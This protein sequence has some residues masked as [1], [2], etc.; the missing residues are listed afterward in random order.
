MESGIPWEL[1][2]PAGTLVFNDYGSVRYYRLEV[3]N[4]MTAAPLRT[5]QFVI[6]QEDGARIGPAY[7]SALVMSF[8]GVLKFDTIAQ[9][10]LMGD[11]LAAWLAT[12]DRADGTLKWTPS[13]LGQRQR[14]VRLFDGPR[15]D[16]ESE[17]VVKR[18]A[19]Q[20]VAGDPLAYSITEDSATGTNFD[21]TRTNDAA[22]SND[23]QSDMWPRIRVNGPFTDLSQVGDNSN[24]RF[25]RFNTGLSLA[26]G[27]YLEIETNPL[28]RRIVDSDGNLRYAKLIPLTTVWPWAPAAAAPNFRAI[29]GSGMTAASTIQV[30]WRDAWRS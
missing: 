5:S 14:T 16:A 10:R 19:F 8:G 11:K 29:A 9:R 22:V 12:L 24:G 15:I 20:L 4:G 2:T 3:A 21:A 28:R 7:R 30:W 23:G 18:F 1:V 27:K 17:T 13:G 26:A 6:P 25:V